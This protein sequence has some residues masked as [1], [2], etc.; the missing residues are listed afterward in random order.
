MGAMALFGEKYDENVRVLSFGD[1][2]VELCGGTHVNNTGDIGIF[3][4]LS[5]SSISSGIRRIEAIT[6][7][8]AENYLKK[9]DNLIS[10][11]CQTLNVQDDELKNKLNI[12]LEDNKKLK[13][14]NSNL[15]KEI[16][17]LKISK[18]IEIKKI[19]L[20]Y[21][22]QI[23]SQNYIDGKIL[24]NIL[25]DIK[26][27]QEK[28]ILAIIQKNNNKVE[29]YILVTKDCFEYFTAKDII[30]NINKSIGSSGGGKD[31]LAQAGI[32]FNDN[33]SDLEKNISQIISEIIKNK[34]K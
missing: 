15:I 28:L 27:T 29:I 14:Q 25:E 7:M 10:D 34:G 26:S 17:Y 20:N 19:V 16:N 30:N 5:E 2:S 32:D 8:S 18:A 11:I 1:V 9:R 13:K 3:K 4:I 33:L 31:D 6:G 12:I 21:N 22:V 24:K 23:L